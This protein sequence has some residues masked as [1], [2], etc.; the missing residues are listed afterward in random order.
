MQLLFQYLVPG[1]WLIVVLLWC[2]SLGQHCLGCALFL[3]QQN[4]VSCS[5]NV[6]SATPNQS[7]AMPRRITCARQQAIGKRWPAMIVIGQNG[8]VCHFLVL[9]HFVCNWRGTISWDLI[10][11]FLT[12]S[13]NIIRNKVKRPQSAFGHGG[14]ANCPLR[15]YVSTTMVGG[16]NCLLRREIFQVISNLAIVY[17]KHL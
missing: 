16:V 6:I 7:N 2:L 9:V 1:V 10:V 17:L 14:T 4:L 15:Y 13:K 3:S 5:K 8:P 11:I 12:V